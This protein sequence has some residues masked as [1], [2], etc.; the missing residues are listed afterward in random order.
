[1]LDTCYVQGATC[2]VLSATCDVR[3]ATCSVRRATCNFG[4]VRVILVSVAA[5]AWQSA[6]GF[7]AQ[8]GVERIVL[9][10]WHGCE[11]RE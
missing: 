10:I 1:M 3:R 4:F 6:R 5:G 2:N 7:Q 11:G 9:D 8:S